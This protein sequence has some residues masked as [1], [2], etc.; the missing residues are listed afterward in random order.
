MVSSQL[1]KKN[2]I[3]KN[4]TVSVRYNAQSRLKLLVSHAN[5]VSANTKGLQTSFYT[6]LFE[7]ARQRLEIIV[8]CCLLTPKELCLQYS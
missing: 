4:P 6:H 5:S 7:Y 1:R 8:Q 3:E 2:S